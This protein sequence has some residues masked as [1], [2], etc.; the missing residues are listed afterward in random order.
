MLAS[1]FSSGV[2]LATTVRARGAAAMSTAAG[3]IKFDMSFCAN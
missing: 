1:F 3:K 2:T